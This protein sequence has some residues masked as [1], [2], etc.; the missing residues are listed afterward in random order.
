MPDGLE[1]L[2]DPVGVGSQVVPRVLD[3][4]RDMT[5][6]VDPRATSDLRR[7]RLGREP[8]HER[9]VPR[10]VPSPSTESRKDA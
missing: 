2:R 3:A 8:L 5:R 10:N 4:E 1:Q 7:H 6:L 9:Q